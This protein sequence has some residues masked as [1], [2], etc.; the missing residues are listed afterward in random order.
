MKYNCDNV[1]DFA[2]EMGRACHA[3]PKCEHC[4]LED[5]G[6]GITDMDAETLAKAIMMI[7]E[8]SDSHPEAEI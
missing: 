6:C 5:I 2:H 7:Q 4:P 3:N 1:A 8:W